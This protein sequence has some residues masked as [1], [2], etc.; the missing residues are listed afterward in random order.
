M[1]FSYIALYFFGKG[2][3]LLALVVSATNL[4]AGQAVR[5]RGGLRALFNNLLF[6]LGADVLP[7]HFF[8]LCSRCLGSS[9]LAAALAEL[10]SSTQ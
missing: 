7:A 10:E 6:E 4:V 5:V 2:V 3:T 9:F 8:G 1:K